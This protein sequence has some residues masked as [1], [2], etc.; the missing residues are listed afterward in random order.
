VSFRSVGLESLRLVRYYWLDGGACTM[1]FEHTLVF[2][3]GLGKISVMAGIA[4]VT[5]S[6]LDVLA[7]L[8]QAHQ[9][10]EDIYGWE[11]K[12]KTRRSGP[13]IYGV[14]DRLEDA[15]LIEGR[16]E[17]QTG[18]DKGPRRRYY[19][20]TD[21]GV[22]VARQL[23][24]IRQEPTAPDNAS[25]VVDDAPRPNEPTAPDNVSGVVDDAP[26]VKYLAFRRVE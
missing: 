20:L 1:V 13:T 7:I 26:R 24:G 21:E 3:H 17:Q 11:I 12:K 4:R 23:L 16:W 14:M 15:D 9:A 8:L 22:V 19:R 25:S 10:H 6:T 18:Q 5:E 2:L